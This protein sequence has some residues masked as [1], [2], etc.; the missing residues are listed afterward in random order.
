V[1]SSKLV[2]SNEYFYMLNLKVVHGGLKK[3]NKVEG[4][5]QHCV[6]ISNWFAA[7]ENSVDELGKLLERI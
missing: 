1:E 6:K 7:L 2:N 4:K 5:G 3:L